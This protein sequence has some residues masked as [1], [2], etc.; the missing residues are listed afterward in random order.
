MPDRQRQYAVVASNMLWTTSVSAGRVLR[1][2]LA[3]AGKVVSGQFY[4]SIRILVKVNTYMQIKLQFLQL[5]ALQLLTQPK[6]RHTSKQAQATC[7]RSLLAGP[8]GR[9]RSYVECTALP[10]MAT[11]RFRVGPRSDLLVR[12]PRPTLCPTDTT[13]H[14]PT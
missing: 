9:A 11:A 7:T 12:C 4:K 2:V 1:W 5:Y 6:T 8:R 14:R 10:P 13:R 3:R